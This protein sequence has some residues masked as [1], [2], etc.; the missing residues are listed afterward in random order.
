[1]KEKIKGESAICG[2]FGKGKDGFIVLERAEVGFLA[3][4]KK[5]IRIFEYA[6]SG[7]KRNVLLSDMAGYFFLPEAGLQKN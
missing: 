4:N 5:R 2:G 7:F 1:M 6:E 3:E